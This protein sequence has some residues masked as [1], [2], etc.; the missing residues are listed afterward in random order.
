MLRALLPWLLAVAIAAGGLVVGWGADRYLV[1]ALLLHAEPFLLVLAVWAAVAA[2]WAGRRAV[3]GAVLLGT[4]SAAVALRLPFPVAPSAGTPPEWMGA[5]SRCASALAPPTEPV[6][7]L[8]WTLTGSEAPDVVQA[9]VAAAGPGVLVLHGVTDP[10][11][12]DVVLQEV[13]GESRFYPPDG[14]GTG[15]AIVAA[16]GFHP[17]GED[18]E[19]NEAMDTPY[20]FTMSFVGVPASTVFPLV[21]TRLP[22]P[23]A[24]GGWSARMTTA[25]TRVLN[26]LAGLH[27][28]STVVVADAPAP[29]TYRTLDERMA[30]VGV[31]S[32]AVPPSWPARLGGLP[33]ITLHPFDRLWVGPSWTDAV[34]TRAPARA[35]LRA[36]V[37]TVLHGP[38]LERS[39]G[40]TVDPLK[41]Q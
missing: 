39:D 34:A 33:L 28:A 35:G 31:A 16:G 29:R 1:T 4:L 13:G 19:W 25:S 3:A 23:L 14:G 30:S 12:V 20:G 41:G 24:G 11:L 21:V 5:V 22:G 6:R 17:C 32:V 37:L 9:T 18:L 10:A 8:Q 2:V 27:G 7:L 38:Q 40:A 15:L 26:A 36:P